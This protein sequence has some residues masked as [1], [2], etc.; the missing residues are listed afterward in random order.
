MG[1]FRSRSRL[2]TQLLT[3][4]AWCGPCLGRPGEI[5]KLKKITEFFT[6]PQ[7][8]KKTNSDFQDRLPPQGQGEDPPQ[9]ALV[10]VH[11]HV[12]LPRAQPGNLYIFFKFF[13][14]IFT[15]PQNFVRALEFRKI[16]GA[17]AAKDLPRPSS[18]TVP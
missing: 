7:K 18:C 17:E 11:V 2:A 16:P 14:P 10:A 5:L 1:N 6:F 15:R 4:A 9:E 8:Y 12:L 13:F 3:A